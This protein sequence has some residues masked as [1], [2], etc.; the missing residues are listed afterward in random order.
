MMFFISTTVA[1]KG[2]GWGMLKNL[3]LYLKVIILTFVQRFLG[4]SKRA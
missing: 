4:Q 3:I 2:F 1:T